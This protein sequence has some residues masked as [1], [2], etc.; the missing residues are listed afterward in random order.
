MDIEQ[1]AA[2]RFLM[3]IVRSKEEK[4]ALARKNI[5]EFYVKNGPC[6]AGCD[7]WDPLGASVGECTRTAP[8]T[9]I[10]RVSMLGWDNV[11]MRIDS[12]HIVTPRE[13]VCGEFIETEVW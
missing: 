1:V 13:H 10:D 7:H 5:K 8:V 6:C 12:G 3:R 4:E 9:G 11:T 2:S